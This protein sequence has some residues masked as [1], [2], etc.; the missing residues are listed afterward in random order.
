MIRKMTQSSTY[1][2]QEKI[3]DL[4]IRMLEDV[5][6]SVAINS[7]EAVRFNSNDKKNALIGNAFFNINS[8]K[9]GEVRSSKFLGTT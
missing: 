5:G 9:F 3:L 4:F 8:C 6:Q 1:Q 2:T 7:M